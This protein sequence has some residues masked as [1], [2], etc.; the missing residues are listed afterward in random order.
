M[1]NPFQR[2]L[3]GL[4]GNPFG[5][6]DEEQNRQAQPTQLPG[7]APQSASVADVASP[8]LNEDRQTVAFDKLGQMGALLMA[9]GQRMT[10]QQR[11]QI[12]SQ[13]VNVMGNTG[14]QL[15]NAAQARLMGTKAQQA[16]DELSR[17]DD[18]KK[19][20][21]ANPAIL[22][23]LGITP[24][25]FQLMGPEAVADALKT[26]MSRDPVQQALAMAQLQQYS[27]PKWETTGYNEFGQ[28]RRDL[29]APNGQ[30]MTPPNVNRG[31]EDI[32]AQLG[33]LS[34]P[35]ALAKLKEVNPSLASEVEQ[36]VN[37]Q[38][39]FPSRK[40]GTA[41]GAMLNRL[42]S[43]VDPTYNANTYQ[44]RTDTQKD[45]NKSQPSSAGGQRQFA[46]VGLQHMAE[47]YKLADKLPDHTNWGPLNT[48][49]NA[50]DIKRQERSAQ[51][52]SINAYK[53]SV[54]NG[55]DEIAKALGIGTGA[56][57]Q[58]LQEK[59]SAAQG[60]SAIKA[61]IREQAQLLKEKMDTLQDRWNEQMGPAAGK[62]R[63]IS[64]AAE[65]ALN[66]II[67]GGEGNKV[68]VN[69]PQ[70][71]IAHLKQ[72]PALRS[73]FDAKYG[74]GSAAKVLGQ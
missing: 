65:K 29:V 4:P 12:L 21:A 53:L 28:P 51:G 47:I 46:N 69:I 44:L 60:P 72:N 52:G 10:P 24:E 45:F 34:G 3:M 7:G 14:A 66:E 74:S 54:I 5:L 26:R 8:M 25:Q 40:L 67:G 63:V 33:N 2:A 13:G 56:G 49:I 61:A 42:V 30:I 31:S 41:E 37:A 11:G 32:T 15:Q 17:Q 20:V 73:A 58:E 19:Q 57:Q 55:F 23:K 64:P 22:E 1:F 68:E 39:P 59:L 6:I 16:Q 35:A 48:T 9:A 18:F 70:D 50:L 27:N 43:V 71:A 38:Q 36:I 62:F